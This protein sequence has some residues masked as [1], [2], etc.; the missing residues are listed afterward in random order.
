MIRFLTKFSLVSLLVLVWLTG[1]CL[2]FSISPRSLV[3]PVPSSTLRLAGKHQS[4]SEFSLLDDDEKEGEEGG[5]LSN[6]IANSDYIV[7]QHR[8]EDTAGYD[9]TDAN[10]E[11]EQ[12]RK[13][14]EY[15]ALSPGTVV[16]VQIGDLNLARKA[17]KKRRRTGSPLLVPCSVLNVD[18]RSM[19]RWNLIFLLEKFGKARA[20]G[21][22]IATADIFKYYRTFLRSSLQVCPIHW[23]CGT[24]GPNRRD[25][26]SHSLNLSL[27]LSSLETN[28]GIG[29]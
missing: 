2:S 10:S 7:V 12:T 16:Q 21:V 23:P 1:S 14:P 26:L 9:D 11:S 20:D 19:V 17:W 24:C 29:F 3:V 4:H 5:E 13:K 25:D 6:K 8:N 18:H 22:E 27:P 28:R 15:G